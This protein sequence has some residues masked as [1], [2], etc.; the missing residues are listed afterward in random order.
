M[1]KNKKGRN[2]MIPRIFGTVT[3]G[4]LNL[5]M[6]ADSSASILASIPNETLL[7]VTEF[8]GTWYATTYGERTGFVMKQFIT[9]LNLADATV[10]YQDQKL[11][12]SKNEFKILQILLENTGKIVSRESI[13]T[14]LWDSNEFIDD[15]TLTVN[16]ARL[17]K[18][19]EQI[20]LGGKIITKKGIGYMVEA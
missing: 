1:P 9:L 12:L 8:N 20:G 15:N 7:I 2:K 3:G 17:R 11:E 10:L 16:V 4:R 6:A 18:K 5:R 14:R 13:M 19:M